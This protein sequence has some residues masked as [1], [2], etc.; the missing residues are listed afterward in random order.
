MIFQSESGFK[1]QK[2]INFQEKTL[3]LIQLGTRYKYFLFV[4]SIAFYDENNKK[5]NNI[6]SFNLNDIIFNDNSIKCLKLKFYRSVSIDKI[7]SSFNDALEIRLKDIENYKNEINLLKK[8]IVDNISNLNFE[9]QFDIL[10][11]NNK[12]NF[13]YNKNFIGE[14]D[15][16]KFS[17][18]IFNC[19]LDKNSVSNDLRNNII[20][21]ANKF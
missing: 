7:I 6:N 4:Y 20:E 9:D 16:E 19:Y 15:N 21:K 12:V 10:L 5:Y 17:L 13:Y 8:I 18:A 14:I 3:D 2:N 1:F 11:V